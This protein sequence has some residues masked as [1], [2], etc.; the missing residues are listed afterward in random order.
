MLL[1]SQLTLS[2]GGP[3][4]CLPFI[5]VYLPFFQFSLSS[6]FSLHIYIYTSCFPPTVSFSLLTACHSP[7]LCNYLL[8]IKPERIRSDRRLVSPPFAGL[9]SSPRPLFFNS[10]SLPPSLPFSMFPCS[11]LNKLCPELQ[12]YTH[13]TLFTLHLCLIFK[14]QNKKITTCPWYMC[15]N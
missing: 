12:L 1:I 9:L 7:I 6:L 14:R 8:R 2:W 11:S 5:S 15:E 10:S 3:V 4:N 13:V